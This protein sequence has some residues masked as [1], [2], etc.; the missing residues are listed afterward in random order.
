MLRIFRIRKKIIEGW[1]KLHD[2][3]GMASRITKEIP[4]RMRSK[5]KHT[6]RYYLKFTAFT[7]NGYW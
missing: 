1:N 6:A 5:V 4:G 3:C 2:I 7:R